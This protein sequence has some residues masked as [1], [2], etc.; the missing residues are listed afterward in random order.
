[1]VIMVPT[2]IILL[3]TITVPSMFIVAVTITVSN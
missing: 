2:T 3:A 1:M